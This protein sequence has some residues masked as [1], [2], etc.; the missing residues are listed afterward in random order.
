M[1]GGVESYMNTEPAHTSVLKR[2][3]IELLAPR[4]GGLYV[5]GTFGAGGHSRAILEAADCRVIGMDRDHHV[6]R[7]AKKL[8]SDFPGRFG[9]TEGRF[10]D[11]ESIVTG[12]G[13]GNVDG[14]LL[15]LGVSSM[16]ID[17]PRRGFS[18]MNDGPLDMRMEDEGNDARF[19]VNHADEED[20]AAIIFKYGDERFSRRIARAIVSARIEQEIT[21]TS[22]LADIIEKAVGRYDDSIHPATRTFQA[23]RIWVND[24]LEQVVSGLHAIEK[25]LAPGGRAAI[26]TF[27]SGEDVI[28]KK[29]FAERSGNI[30]SPSRHVPMLPSQE[31]KPLFTLVNKKAI[32]PTD[33][34]VALN[35]R[36]R[37]AKLR[38]VERTGV[39]SLRFS[40]SKTGGIQ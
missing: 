17:T 29:F 36:S 14:V 16:Q 34:E 5:D 22:E 10:G 7:F 37:S 6:T 31:I 11:M 21:R 9:F 24:E 20:L 1:L 19:L 18:F 2:E 8:I 13:V 39:G 40:G 33:E 38:V 30:P 26:I 28:V 27:H 12:L 3:V 35:P 32:R 23:L 15:D 25:V 4:S